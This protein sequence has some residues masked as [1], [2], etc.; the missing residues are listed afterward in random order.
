MFIHPH[1]LAPRMKLL[2]IAFI[3]S[4]LSYFRVAST[5]LKVDVWYILLGFKAICNRFLLKSCGCKEFRV[6]YM[7]RKGPLK[8]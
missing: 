3:H 5:L 2:L 1:I 8:C 4:V 7:M 6:I